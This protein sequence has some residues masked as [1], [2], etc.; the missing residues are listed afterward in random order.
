MLPP[1]EPI[2]RKGLE[3]SAK[4]K[5][6]EWSASRG[7]CRKC[8]RDLK[9][10]GSRKIYEHVLPIWLGGTNARAN[11]R[12]FCWDCADA[13]TRGET[14]ERARGHRAEA[15]HK[16]ELKPRNPVPFSRAHHLGKRANGEIYERSTGR[17]LREGRKSTRKLRPEYRPARQLHEE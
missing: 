15:R 4:T 12:L 13:K 3:F 5:R 1:R 7:C 9:P 17:V 10:K 11:C 16:G 6:K 8:G 2:S 14:G